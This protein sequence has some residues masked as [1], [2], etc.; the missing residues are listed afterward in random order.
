MTAQVPVAHSTG[1]SESRVSQ[2]LVSLDAF[3][4]LTIALMILVNNPGD[5]GNIYAPLKHAQWN[6]CTP[7]D[8]VFP[9]FLFI[10]GVAIPLAHAARMKRQRAGQ[11]RGALVP[12]II[13]RTIILFALGLLLASIPTRISPGNGILDPANLRIMGVLQ[14]IALCYLPAAL[15]GLYVGWR[16][17]ALVAVGLMALYSVLMLAVP[18]PG[19]GAGNLAIEGNLAAYVD[20]KLLG[21]HCYQNPPAKPYFWEPEG[22]LSTLPAIAT[23][24]LGVITGQWLRSDRDGYEKVA[25]LLVFG[26]FGAAL[27]YVLDRI[28]MPINKG[29][30]TPSY[31]IYTAGL[32]LLALGV[33]YW[34]IDLKRYQAWS[35]AVVIFGMNSIAI[36]VLSGIIG[37]LLT[38]RIDLDAKPATLKSFIY[39]HIFKP[40]GL[41][42]VNT[43]LLYALTWIALMFAIAWLLYRKRIFIKV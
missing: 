23:T 13:R 36:F 15:L 4:G 16:T 7:T 39:D 42:A 19:H 34:L 11:N 30:W 24:L 21:N 35:R 10:V 26:G 2:R 43:S 18:V 12:A 6:G 5:W 40:V 14:R 38:I 20:A 25:G 41:S 33:C 1:S 3:R 9:F 29:L 17:H 22:L 28:L 32:A 8:L 31:V 27:G 37:R